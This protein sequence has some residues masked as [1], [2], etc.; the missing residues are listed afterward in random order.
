MFQI[1]SM[2]KTLLAN[3]IKKSNIDILINNAGITGSTAPCGN[4]M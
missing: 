1:M 4:M 2:L 3:I